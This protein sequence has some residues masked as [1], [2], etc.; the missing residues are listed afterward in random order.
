MFRTY[1]RQVAVQHKEML[2]NA[3]SLTILVAIFGPLAAYFYTWN[4]TYLLMTLEKLMLNAVVVVLKHLFGTRGIAARPAAAT[5]CDLFCVG[6]PVG[7]KE[8]MPSGHMATATF[9]VSAMYSHTENNIWV[10][11]VGIPWIVAMAWSRWFKS[12]HNVWQ[13]VAGALLGLL[14]AWLADRL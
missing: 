7:G 11:V 3:V 10:L 4:T 12:C 14:A 2:A 5:A 1:K 6:P 8:G 13:L 9:F